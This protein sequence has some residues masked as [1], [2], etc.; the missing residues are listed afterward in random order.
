MS[1]LLSTV[2]VAGP[3][4]HDRFLAPLST[5]L[6]EKVK[7]QLCVAAEKPQTNGGGSNG[8]AKPAP[9][10]RGNNK[11]QHL[12]EVK[13]VN[14]DS[15]EENSEETSSSSSEDEMESASEGHVTSDEEDMTNKLSNGM[16]QEQGSRGGG[17][18]VGL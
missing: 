6:K 15:S 13:D 9:A 2:S 3:C 5:S 1:A 12:Q 14:S 18:G 8:A 16:S 11:F 17:G 10:N 7:D 4:Q